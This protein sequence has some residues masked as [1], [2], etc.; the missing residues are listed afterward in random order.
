MSH[1]MLPKASHDELTEQLFVRDLK[2]WLA[3]QVEP[4]ARALADKLDPGASSN[5]RTETTYERL[6]EDAAFRDW[7]SVRR[8]SQELMWDAVG[9]SVAR[10]RDALET[11]AAAASQLGSLTLDPNFVLPPYLAE[12]DVHLMPGG[13]HVEDYGVG[14]GAVMD[15]GGAVYMLGKN[16]GFLNDGRGKTIVQHLFACYPDFQPN[17]ILELGCGIGASL[18]PL[19]AA[20]PEAEVHGIDVGAS[21]LRYALARA[22]HLGVAID[23]AQG[24]AERTRYE[25]AS[26]D[27]VF[28]ATLM[29]E[30]S[31]S[32]IGRVLAESRR[33]LRPGGVAI[34]LEVPQRYET[35]D[36]WGKIRGKIEADYN[37]E[38]A[39]A[40]AIGTDYAVAMRSAGFADVVIG[41]QDA[42]FAPKRDAGGFS[43]ESKG[44][45]RSW[46]VASGRG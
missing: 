42:C 40:A 29:H 27:L 30:T 2:V 18:V 43:D 34:H 20:F 46:F 4:Q 45:F 21:M 23:F 7:A 31:A 39:W 6:H 17:R 13:Y 22:R 26:F 16:G 5:A 41:Y 36:L 28:S 3:D 32:A 35:M 33:L 44:V 12:G 25:N 11:T 24:D 19:A 1:A 8:A 10:Q 37:N 9:R 38:P 15:R 14:Q